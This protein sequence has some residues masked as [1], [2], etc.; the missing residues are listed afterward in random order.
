MNNTANSR[1]RIRFI[2]LVIILA[3]I[4]CYCSG[5]LLVRTAG[6]TQ[7]S[8]TSTPLWAQPATQ[9]A[10]A[11]TALIPSFT[12]IF[13]TATPASPTS[14][15]TFPTWTRPPTSTPTHTPTP[16]Q[17]P[18]PTVQPSFTP[19][20]TLT[21]TLPPTVTLTATPEPTEPDQSP[22]TNTPGP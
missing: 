1:F 18:L 7:E 14:V 8:P 12:P 10:A 22:P 20:A 3:T 5:L 13:V 6:T 19:T 21:E 16:S 11:G 15:Q 4:P 2:L 17:P 9:T